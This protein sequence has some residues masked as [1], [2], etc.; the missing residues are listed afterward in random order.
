MAIVSTFSCAVC[1]RQRQIANHW[2]LVWTN[3]GQFVSQPWHDDLA[4]FPTVQHCCGAECATT[5]Y[6]RFLST[7]SL[8]KTA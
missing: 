8:E 2:L 7:G 3:A 1:Q 4:S 5:L 6:S